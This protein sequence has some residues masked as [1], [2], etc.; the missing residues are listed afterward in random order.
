MCMCVCVCVC[1]VCCVLEGQEMSVTLSAFVGA[2]TGRQSRATENCWGHMGISFSLFHSLSLS[3]SLS[4]SRS[5][6]RSLALVISLSP[7]LSL[8]SIVIDVSL[9][10]SELKRAGLVHRWRAGDGIALFTCTP[11]TYT[12]THTHTHT[13]AR[14]HTHT[15][16]YSSILRSVY[17]P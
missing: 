8:R 14:T 5:L 12:H 17:L 13:G 16:A 4:L 1:D 2:A 7:S 9:F 11:H 3:L 15:H 6:G 10:R